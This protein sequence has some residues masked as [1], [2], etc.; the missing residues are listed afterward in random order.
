[1]VFSLKKKLKKGNGVL[2]ALLSV[3]KNITQRCSKFTCKKTIK[4]QLMAQTLK[5]LKKCIKKSDVFIAKKG[6]FWRKQIHI[7]WYM[8][9]KGKVSV[10]LK[11]NGISSLREN[12]E[13]IS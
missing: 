1:M 6:C 3:W 5:K 13:L 11:K 4:F 7:C 2:Y 9:L 8:V 12:T 10:K